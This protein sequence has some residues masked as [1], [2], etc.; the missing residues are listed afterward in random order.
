MPSRIE[1]D[2]PAGFHARLHGTLRDARERKHG[3][4]V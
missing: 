2:L 3:K 1:E 4:T